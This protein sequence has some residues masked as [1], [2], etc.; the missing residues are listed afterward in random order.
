MSVRSDLKLYAE[1]SSPIKVL[2]VG[3]EGCGKSTML[4]RYVDS[5]F[6]AAYIPTI[7]VD[8]KIKMDEVGKWTPKL[9]IW[10]TAGQQRFKTIISSYFRGAHCIILCFDGPESLKEIEEEFYKDVK[11]FA[12]DKVTVTMCLCKAD[13][14]VDPKLYDSATEVASN[15]NI[16]LFRC[17]SKHDDGVQEVFRSTVAHFLTGESVMQ[18]LLPAAVI[19]KHVERLQAAGAKSLW[20]DDEVEAYTAFCRPLSILEQRM[21]TAR[22]PAQLSLEAQRKKLLLSRSYIV[23]VESPEAFPRLPELL[24]GSQVSALALLDEDIVHF[25]ETSSAEVE[26]LIRFVNEAPLGRQLRALILH[27]NAF[28]HEDIISRLFATSKHMPCLV[29]D[30]GSVNDTVLTRDMADRLTK[31]WAMDPMPSFTSISF[32]TSNHLSGPPVGVGWDADAIDA[33]IQFRTAYPGVVFPDRYD[34]GKWRRPPLVLPTIPP[35]V[36]GQP[37]QLQHNESKA[38]LG[39]LDR[40]VAVKASVLLRSMLA[41]EAE[42]QEP[43]AVPIAL[44]ADISPTAVKCL[45]DFLNHVA[46]PK[47][48]E[49]AENEDESLPFLPDTHVQFL[50]TLPGFGENVEDAP[51]DSSCLLQLL[52]LA[53]YFDIPIVKRLVRTVLSFRLRD[54]EDP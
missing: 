23:R 13:G 34:E 12:A 36:D 42:N 22:D 39:V 44:D 18:H 26:D 49:G 8:F 28:Q 50:R 11:K 2:L 30:V 46:T 40:T 27:I 5:K 54:H 51:A 25:F 43:I 33:I 17:S 29:I 37:I 32:V 38:I 41:E 53:M 9:Q 1:G 35:C 20:C 19:Q 15:F 10:D 48:M 7:G 52:V 14:D 31:L 21:F 47:E 16:A 45:C 24:C 3:A 4:E 6:T